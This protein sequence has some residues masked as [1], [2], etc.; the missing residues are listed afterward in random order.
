[1]TGIWSSTLLSLPP[2]HNLLSVLPPSH[3]FHA[4]VNCGAVAISSIQLAA[5]SNKPAKQVAKVVPAS[6]AELERAHILPIRGTQHNHVPPAAL[7][8]IHAL[9]VLARPAN[10]R[11]HAVRPHV[12]GRRPRLLAHVAAR[13]H[14]VVLRLVVAPD[15][16]H[17]RRTTVER[18]DVHLRVRVPVHGG[19]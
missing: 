1:M 8:R 11:P 14:I 4:P 18:R 16:S 6:S 7:H 19:A 10:R 5:N 13:G 9:Q 12:A 15:L 3:S 2:S 17:R